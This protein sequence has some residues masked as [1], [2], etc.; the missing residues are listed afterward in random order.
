MPLE[1][2]QVRSDVIMPKCNGICGDVKLVALTFR[3]SI[4]YDQWWECK[5]LAE[6][7]IDQGGGFRDSLCDIAEELCPSENHGPLP[8][9][10]FIR[11]PNQVGNLAASQARR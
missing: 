3:W 11:A 8:L 10:L 1:V 5:F 7:I 9:P 2:L 4:R 6:G